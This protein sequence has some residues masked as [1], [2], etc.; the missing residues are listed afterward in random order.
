MNIITGPQFDTDQ[1]LSRYLLPC[2]VEGVLDMTRYQFTRKANRVGWT[3]TMALKDVRTRIMQKKRDCLFTTQNWN[4]AV[5][6]GRYVEFW[7]DLYNLGRFVISRG[8]EW[9]TVM[10]DDGKGGKVATQEKVGIYKF[11]GG[12]RLILFSSS[13][14]AIQ[15]FE[16]DVRWDECEF[17]E[18]QEQMHAALST[19]IQFGYDYHAWSACNGVNT[20]VNQVLY[21]IATKP[22]SGWKVRTITIYDVI[23]QGLVEKI[24]ERAGTNMTREEFLED[25]RR[26]ALTPAIFAERFECNPADSGSSIVPWSV[27]ERCRDQFI[28]RHHLGDAQIKEMFGLPDTSADFRMRKMRDW[29]TSQYG[30]LHRRKE[31]M[32][33]GFD[34]A[35]SGKGD[36]ASFWIDAK[37][38]RGL[39][40]R[41]LLTTQTEDWDFL[42]AALMWFMGLPDARGCGDATG[43]GRQITWTAEQRTGG[44]FVGVPWTRPS[45]SEMGSRLMNALTSGE[46]RLASGH[47]D[48]AMDIFSTQKEVT[49]GVLTFEF[50]TNPLNGASHGDMC[51]SKMFC[52]HTEATGNGADFGFSKVADPFEGRE[53]GLG[54]LG[55]ARRLVGW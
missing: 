21:K 40:Q 3:W 11:D 55:R 8:E 29:M 27:I 26:R 32:R 22:G 10:R 14:W 23:E 45:K 38:A 7:L 41:A 25:C 52:N 46:C 6:F 18:H 13:P 54:M 19:R 5:E 35:A 50:G 44:R 37:T 24:N 47:D 49:G 48:V 16:G 9:I 39:E 51:A 1:G 20:W 33:I 28:Y 2:Q 43:L 15:T 31:K 34:V 30:A 4:G 36:L 17:H 42:T 12:S 53:R